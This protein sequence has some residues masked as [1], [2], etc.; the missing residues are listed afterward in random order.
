MT[1]PAAAVFSKCPLQQPLNVWLWNS[2]KTAFYQCV[3][4]TFFKPAVTAADGPAR[5][6]A[7]RSLASTMVPGRSAGV[8]LKGPMLA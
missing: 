3:D 6:Q 5:S 7:L 8:V 4:R 1:L 2:R